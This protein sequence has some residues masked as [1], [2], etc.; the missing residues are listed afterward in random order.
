MV[1]FCCYFSSVAATKKSR[2]LKQ[3]V[4]LSFIILPIDWPQLGWF[5]SPCDSGGDNS[6]PGLDW[7]VVSEQAGSLPHVA[8]CRCC[9][10]AGPSA[11]MVPEYLSSLPHGLNV[12]AGGRGPRRREKAKAS[13]G[14]RSPR[15]FFYRIFLAREVMGPVQTEGTGEGQVC[16]QYNE[17]MVANSGNCQPHQVDSPICLEKSKSE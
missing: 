13:C 15:R 17:S 1:L 14:P 3:V 9:L 6:N 7:T 11:D 4:L 5:S 12:I 2:C 16:G 10:L 8:S